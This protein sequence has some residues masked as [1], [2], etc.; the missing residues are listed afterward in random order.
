MK[1][2]EAEREE[3]RRRRRTLETLETQG[4]LRLWKQE[5]RPAANSTLTNSHG[6]NL[7]PRWIF[8][9]KTGVSLH[10]NEKQNKWEES[11]LKGPHDAKNSLP[12]SSLDFVMSQRATRYHPGVC[13]TTRNLLCDALIWQENLGVFRYW[14]SAPRRF[15]RETRS[16]AT[17]DFSIWFWSAQ[18]PATLS[19][20]P[21][22]VAS[23]LSC[24]SWSGSRLRQ[25][26]TSFHIPE[27]TV[28][29]RYVKPLLSQLL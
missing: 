20:A 4:H 2:S 18:R 23:S 24:P 21:V 11:R 12:C 9:V 15:L 10:L 28:P 17:L 26:Q 29:F 14:L 27:S 8:L 5:S 22:C 16:A 25:R 3:E 13:S 6:L 19:V 1:L 7:S